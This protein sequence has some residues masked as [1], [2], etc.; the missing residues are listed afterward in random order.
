MK[1]WQDRGEVE[2]SEGDEDLSL[3][4]DTP[5]PER[6]HKRAKHTGE[7]TVEE[8]ALDRNHVSDDEDESNWIQAKVATTYGRGGNIAKHSVAQVPR[9]ETSDEKVE[10]VASGPDLG[11]GNQITSRAE[12]LQ[13]PTREPTPRSNPDTAQ[14]DHELLATAQSTKAGDEGSVVKTASPQDDQ[15]AATDAD[16]SPK[17]IHSRSLT[18]EIVQPQ[19]AANVL[20][21]RSLGHD[22]P[23]SLVIYDESSVR[24]PSFAD[25]TSQISD[26]LRPQPGALPES[27]P[28][29]PADDDFMH[30]SDLLS[31]PL[32]ERDVSPP[33]EFLGT[34]TDMPASLLNDASDMSDAEPLPQDL[35]DA[36]VHSLAAAANARRSLRARQEKQL[37]PYM[38]DKAQ[39]QKQFRERGLKPVRLMEEASANQ[40]SQSASQS[41]ASQSS[42]VTRV[43]SPPR[44]QSLHFPSTAH[45]KLDY[46]DAAA[47]S[48]DDD[49][50]DHNRSIKRRKIEAA[51]KVRPG[52]LPTI[53]RSLAPGRHSR[54]P[55]PPRTSSDIET[56][57]VVARGSRQNLPAFKLPPGRTPASLPTPQISSDIRPQN[58]DLDSPTD[59][60]T[61]II[62]TTRRGSDSLS[63]DLSSS[64]SETEALAEAEAK[65]LR[66]EQKRIK[67]VLPASWLRIDFRKQRV[68]PSASPTG[69]R[70]LSAEPSPRTGPQK[71]VARKVF[72]V[73]SRQDGSPGLH[74][75]GGGESDSD[76]SVR[77]LSA[78]PKQPRLTLDDER[79]SINAG[80]AVVD[81]EEM[82]D[83]F[84]DPMLVG[85]PRSAKGKRRPQTQPR[86]TDAFRST[87]RLDGN[88]MDGRVSRKRDARGAGV[89]SKKQRQRR[90]QPRP[91][92]VSARL[93]IMDAPR[94]PSNND[95]TL[96]QFVRL[97]LR[98]ARRDP[99]RGRHSPTDKVLRLA[100]IEETEEA[101]SV[102]R[103]WR[104]GTI[105]PRR[106]R[107]P[108]K[109][110][111]QLS[112]RPD[113]VSDDS[114]TPHGDLS[115][116][117]PQP[118]IQA[119]GRRKSA[120][121]TLHVRRAP[122]SRLR[123]TQIE[124]ATPDERAE[125][126]SLE[127]VHRVRA[128]Q[129][130]QVTENS[131]L[132][133][134]QLETLETDFDHMHRSAAF[135]RRMQ[136]LTEN[137]ALPE[138]QP[139]TPGFQ[140][141]RFLHADDDGMPN[142]DP[143]DGGAQAVEVPNPILPHRPRKS[144]AHRLET[145]TRR[146]R[147]PSEPLPELIVNDDDVHDKASP[148]EPVLEGLGPFGTRYSIDFDIEPLALG[149]FFQHTTF[150]GSG[151]LN[152]ALNLTKR[153]LH[154]PAGRM[155][156]QLDGEMLD[157][158]GWNED[159]AANFA[160]IPAACHEALQTLQTSDMTCD[161]EEQ[162]N[163]VDSNIDYLLRSVLRFCSKCLYFVDAVDR[164]SCAESLHRLAVDVAD[165]FSEPV[166]ANHPLPKTITKVLQYELVILK[167]ASQVSNHE[168]V[169]TATK[170]HIEDQLSRTSKRLA[171]VAVLGHFDE[172]RSIYE[173][174]KHH[175]R[176]DA[177]IDG[178]AFALSSVVILNNIR[179]ASGSQSLLWSAIYSTMGM[180]VGQ[181]CAVGRFE[182]LWYDLFSLL[183]ALEVTATGTVSPG[184]RLV[185]PQENWSLPQSML[186]RAMQ[187]YESSSEVRGY[188]VNDYMRALLSRCYTL[189]NKWGWW[190]CESVLNDVYDFFSRRGLALLKKEDGRGSPKFLDQLG[191]SLVELEVRNDDRSFHIF[192]KILASGLVGM[193]KYRLY[194]DRKIQG[195]AWRFIPNHNRTYRKDADLERSTL[196]ALRNHHDL[197][198]TLY[199]A[200]PPGHR[201]GVHL[202]REL[203]DHSTSHREA[204]RLNVRSWANIASFQASITE[205][206]DALRPL[207]DWFSDIMKT[208]IAQYRLAK[209]EAQ[210]A[211]DQAKTEGANPSEA[212][213]ESTVT[214]NQRQL[215]ATVVDALAGLKRA[216]SSASSLTVA[217]V[218]LE[219]T[220]FWTVF[221]LFDQSQRR[222]VSAMTEALHVVEVALDVE[223]RLTLSHESQ[224]GSDD[225]QDFGD[226]DA[227][228]EFAAIDNTTSD[229]ASIVE[230]LLGP[231]GHFMSNAL[232]ADV[233][234]DDHLLQNAIDVWVRL[235]GVTVKHAKKTWLDYVNDYS[236]TGWGQ[237]R[238]TAQK[239]KF[240]TYF[241]SR[242]V[243]QSTSHVEISHHVMTAWL[244][245][246]VEREALLKFQHVLTSALLMHFGGDR[247]LQNLPFARHHKGE[248]HITLSELRQRRLALISSIFCNMREAHEQA[249]IGR[250]ADEVRMVFEGMLRQLMQ[251][252]KSNYQELQMTHRGAVADASVQGAYV[253]FVQQVVSFLQQHTTGICKVDGFFTDSTVFPLPSGDPTYVVGRLKGYTPHLRKP[254][255]RKELATFVQSVGERAAVDGQQPYLVNQMSTA[256]KGVA[257]R[258]NR[259]SPSLR[260]LLLT[261][262]FPAYIEG[263]LTTACSWIMALPVL[264][265]CEQVIPDLI[266]TVKIE[267]DESVMAAIESV[268]AVLHSIN[269]QFEKILDGF[270]GM[271][272]LS[273]V[274]HTLSAMLLVGRSSLTLASL[275]KRSTSHGDQLMRQ[276][277]ALRELGIEIAERLENPSEVGIFEASVV[278]DPPVSPWSDTRSYAETQ[279]RDDMHLWHAEDGRYYLKRYGRTQEAVMS[280]QDCEVEHRGLLRVI[281]DFRRAYDA[282][283][284]ARSRRRRSNAGGIGWMD[285]V[286]V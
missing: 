153:D 82:E 19:F 57:T 116:N 97:A 83:D 69:R 178:S 148:L 25:K 71:G 100:T 12:D 108:T 255:A 39:Y 75:I 24:E 181:T 198:C 114:R 123:Q 156:V 104:E 172:L 10:S 134:A 195:I 171:S 208:T 258:G 274:L 265:S 227:L 281:D 47:G 185:R 217:T 245:S 214:N 151:E 122:K 21:K 117:G 110:G 18:R 233:A 204:C 72:A 119:A 152:D 228:Q 194:G 125:T 45:P 283:F 131:R 40:E 263:A 272:G 206:L 94:S 225:S 105:A 89:P 257:E 175:G 67:G 180:D 22:E 56:P 165:T 129:R 79:L 88:T 11:N 278:A 44:S 63:S 35:N 138:R 163:A 243:E 5:S 30:L 267:D 86:I 81:D 232:G 15:T 60:P 193:G 215:A 155:R 37:H 73:R 192:L 64:E 6:P 113:N 36:D 201:P 167:Q 38:Y 65:R 169:S 70:R 128:P 247:L 259:H 203:V 164:Q 52:Q 230:I 176:R 101:S 136:F 234:P 218:L 59:S 219:D 142:G 182:K 50:N 130:R 200:S 168:I 13:G 187:L 34:R 29:A 174:N 141:A 221:E 46:F 238:D 53:N 282:T 76:V 95:E 237:M 27:I 126:A 158:G 224:H 249:G 17:S 85:I 144:K 23:A 210:Q 161:Q 189:V 9:R 260:H 58:V 80:E 93:S 268:V 49:I 188:S 2:D 61:R 16:E 246:L 150:I 170:T 226:S 220:A 109:F 32:S 235:A 216:L 84:I 115:A 33:L 92:P 96:P 244:L 149:T 277:R 78:F 139:R 154:C 145:G 103:A 191:S 205:S 68:P 270:P 55:S 213:L 286:V 137:I 276:I 279:L 242:V 4:T 31:S 262:M 240:T 199:Y 51:G 273:H 222:L 239:R 102:L 285:D 66:R 143:Q 48:S 14:T 253:D 166:A 124:S 250:P 264:R 280:L 184:S 207:T 43:S 147:Q 177:G 8:T 275:I 159:V 252:M 112:R 284:S 106:S 179:P 211:F 7:N 186:R 256:M 111:A 231:V 91:R 20:L 99:S 28:S 42:D 98:R 120:G 74:G 41:A 197:V 160:R 121:S 241:M 157:W 1:R 54:P 266:Y 162:L 133:N 3:D 173:D 229:S 146:Y 251:A 132:R 77:E 209:S 269:Q 107:S 135:E 236:A 62:N 261:T 26:T 118:R 248:F 183:P 90:R 87:S 190:R 196:D 254:K 223:K 140:L 202:L 271:L 127:P 212:L